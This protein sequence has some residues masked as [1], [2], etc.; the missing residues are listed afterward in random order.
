M[1]NKLSN[2]VDNLSEINNKDS[3]T[4]IEKK[5]IK[6]ESEFI[7]LENK[8]LNYRCKEW[9][10]TSNKSINDLIEKFPRMYQF[11]NG[12]LNKFVLLLRKGVCY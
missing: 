2:F 6:S 10:R 12:D 11:C 4:C 8:R 7:G 1:P 5:K 9:N 3:K